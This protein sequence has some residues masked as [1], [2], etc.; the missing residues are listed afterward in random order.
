MQADIQLLW[1]DLH[2]ELRRFIL[3]KVRDETLADDLLQETFLKVHL[4]LGGLK[5]CH[6]LT[7]WVYQITRN[8]IIDHFRKARPHLPIGDLEPVAEEEPS[9]QNLSRCINEKI[10]VLPKKH[11][12]ALLLTTFK[13][14]PQTELADYLGISYSG[15]K[16]RVQRGRENLVRLVADCEFVETSK[17]GKI[18][19]HDLDE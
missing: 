13:E 10:K 3:G 5:D 12:E 18:T 16:S 15:A 1:R 6:K 4:R 9:F 8:V 14:I 11:R 17:Q 19:G 7:S 2:L